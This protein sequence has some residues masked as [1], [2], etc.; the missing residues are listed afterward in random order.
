MG[1]DK[2]SM[3]LRQGGKESPFGQVGS[4]DPPACLPNAAMCAV[5]TPAPAVTVAPLNPDQLCLYVYMSIGA[6]RVLTNIYLFTHILIQ[7]SAML[8]MFIVETYLDFLILALF[9]VFLLGLF[10]LMIAKVIFLFIYF[11]FL[12]DLTICNTGLFN[13]SA[14]LV[15]GEE[16]A[17]LI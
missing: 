16:N 6:K 9:L 8:Q 10:L 11:F 2:G 12:F 1:G 13:L 7:S 14:A 15:C 17:V 5:L 4:S 3:K